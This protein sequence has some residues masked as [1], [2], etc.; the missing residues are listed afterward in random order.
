MMDFFIYS[1]MNCNSYKDLCHPLV[2]PGYRTVSST[3][4][5][6]L[7][8]TCRC[9]YL[10]L[11]VLKKTH[12]IKLTML[13]IFKVQLSSVKNLCIVVKQ[14]SRTFASHRTET[15]CPLNNNSPLPLPPAPGWQPPS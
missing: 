2:Q 5:T 1:S 14:I 9:S 7:C 10:T 13:T 3:R 8:Q 12:I 11:C 15:L 4:K 6:P